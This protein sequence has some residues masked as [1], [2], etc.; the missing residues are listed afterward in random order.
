MLSKGE[1]ADNIVLVLTHHRGYDAQF[2]LWGAWFTEI[3]VE[4]DWLTEARNEANVKD[5]F[6]ERSRRDSVLFIH[7]SSYIAAF[8]GN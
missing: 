2:T 1:K 7:P 6:T 5:V 3:M 4:S 8:S